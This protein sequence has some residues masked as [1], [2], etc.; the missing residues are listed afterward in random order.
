MK[1]GK[2]CVEET[3]RGRLSDFEFGDSR[4]LKWMMRFPDPETIFFI[5]GQSASGKTFLGKCIEAEC[6]RRKERCVRMNADTF[7]QGV[8]GSICA[9]GNTDWYYEQF[10]DADVVIIDEIE[11]FSGRERAQ[12]ELCYFISRMKKRRAQIILTGLYI[13]E[14]YKLLNK[15]AKRIAP[16]VKV[17]EL[18]PLN[19]RY[20]ERFV[21]RVLRRARMKMKKE[22]IRHICEA[23]NMGAVVG[24]LNAV[25]VQ[26]TDR[27]LCKL[28]DLYRLK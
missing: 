27:G 22:D 23:E 16:N 21:R 4:K 5:Y 12:L 6:A 20:R 15:E 18:K 19:L 11:T 25:L 1:N 3:F 2:R 10:Y 17:M 7:I 9:Y 24:M 28:P 8:I 13:S 14:G 26:H